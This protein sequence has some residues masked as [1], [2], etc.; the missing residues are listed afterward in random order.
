[1]AGHA[2]TPVSTFDT[3]TVPDDGEPCVATA[4]GAPA[5]NIT[6]EEVVQNLAN[7]T[8]WLH[9]G[10]YHGFVSH[11]SLRTV[12]VGAARNLTLGAY[13]RITLENAGTIRLYSSPASSTTITTAGL[14]ANTWYYVYCYNDGTATLAFDVSTTA[15]DISNTFKTG[16]AT[17]R[18]L[19][20][21]T[22][23][24]ASKIVPFMMSDGDYTLRRGY[25]NDTATRLALWAAYNTVAYTAF[26]AKLPASAGIARVQVYGSSS[27]GTGQILVRTA[28]DTGAGVIDLR[29][30]NGVNHIFAWIWQRV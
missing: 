6:L 29:P 11:R 18:Y 22:T 3:V 21:F 14:A 8:Q 10:P 28:G 2:I 5:T 30:P 26:S 15:P 27:A 16:D 4:P 1:M 25:D 13:H 19:G 12:H 17:R 20:C 7:R 9:D 23:E 24:S